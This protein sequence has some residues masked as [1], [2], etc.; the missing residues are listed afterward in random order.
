MSK[1]ISVVFYGYRLVSDK[2]QPPVLPQE[3]KVFVAEVS[4]KYKKYGISI[5]C[6]DELENVLEVSGYSDLLNTVRLRT[7]DSMLGNPCLGHVIGQSQ[8]CNLLEDIQRGISR[9]AFAPETIEPD[10]SSK[11]VCHNCGCGC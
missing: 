10:G 7:N 8:N 11:K 4:K 6:I 5:S 2:W 3:P 9:V 1:E